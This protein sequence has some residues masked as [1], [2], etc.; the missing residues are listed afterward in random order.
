[1]LG[2]N[3]E[4]LE[5][6]EQNLLNLLRSC[7]GFTVDFGD[8]RV[9]R[10]VEVR[11]GLLHGQPRAL[12]VETGLF[13]RQRVE[14]P[15]VDVGSVMPTERRVVLQYPGIAGLDGQGRTVGLPIGEAG[16]R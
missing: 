11:F 6:A 7:R 16:E 9:G 13:E 5:I 3:P 12:I 14:V 4:R 8:G 15:T 10:V 1:M 2:E